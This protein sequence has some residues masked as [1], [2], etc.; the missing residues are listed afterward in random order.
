RR[1]R[2][3]GVSHVEHAFRGVEREIVDQAPL[4]IDRLRAHTGWA[5]EQIVRAQLGNVAPK[6]IEEE[7]LAQ[8]PRELRETGAPVLCG[9]RAEAAIAH[10]LGEIAEVDVAAPVAL[11]RGGEDRGRSAPQ[12][13]FDA[14]RVV[15][16]AEREPR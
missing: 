5:G 8:V 4:M 1:G 7:A 12:R 9:E 6:R 11:A 15:D 3:W 16:V 10:G 14:Q 13:S 2:R